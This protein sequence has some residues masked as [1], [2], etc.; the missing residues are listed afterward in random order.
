MCKPSTFWET[1][2]LRR[3]ILSI[4]TKAIWV[5]EGI[6]VFISTTFLLGCYLMP[7][8]FFS[9]TPGPVFNTV[10]TPDLKS[11]IPQAVEIPAPVKA[12]KCLLFKIKSATSLTF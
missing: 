4:A 5:Y 12:M 3:L 1:K 9:H 8:A 6:A 11:G 2:Y 7:W 10:S